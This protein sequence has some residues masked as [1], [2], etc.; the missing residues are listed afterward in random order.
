MID[1]HTK[2]LIFYLYQKLLLLLIYL[3][4]LAFNTSEIRKSKNDGFGKSTSLM[5][6]FIIC[7]LKFM[8]LR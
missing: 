7:L 8:I 1:I 3:I 6:N 2:F 4:I 5:N